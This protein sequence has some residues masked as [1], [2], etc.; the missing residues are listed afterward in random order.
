MDPAPAAPPPILFHYTTA[1]GLIG[2]LPP[3]RPLHGNWVTLK[4]MRHS[5]DRHTY[6]HLTSDS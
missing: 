2:I 4:L 3:A 5:R 6:R 1:S